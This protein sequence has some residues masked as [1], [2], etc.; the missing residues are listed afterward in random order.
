MKAAFSIKDIVALDNKVGSIDLTVEYSV[1]EFIELIRQYPNLI[2]Q[3]AQL[4]KE[5]QNGN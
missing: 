5:I 2:N 3:V 1:E 4:L